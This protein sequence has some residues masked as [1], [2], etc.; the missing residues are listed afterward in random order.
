MPDQKLNLPQNLIPNEPELKD[1]FALFRK[2]VFLGLNCHAIATVQSFNADNQTASA[3][4]NYKKTFFKPD[5]T[6]VYNPTLVNYPQLIDCPVI[7]L[8][9]GGASLTFPVAQGDECL[10]LFN[11]RDL[12]RWFQ[13]NSNINPATPRLHSFSDAILLVGLRSLAN[14]VP[15]FNPDNAEI[16]TGS[17]KVT[18]RKEGGVFIE[19]NIG[20]FHFADNADVNF[21]TGTVQGLFGHGGH[22]K[23]ENSTGELIK[24][25]QDLATAI[26]AGTAGGFP[27]V[28]PPGFATA[29]ATITSFVEP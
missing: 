11:D 10:V 15:N 29:L 16:Q 7:F 3:T 24:A 21:D 5:A 20:N 8:G 6:G 4:V 9:G 23:F 27:L 18:F 12:D 17:L 1:L 28:F 26:E 25:L 14:S 13:G 19:N 22:V 2:E